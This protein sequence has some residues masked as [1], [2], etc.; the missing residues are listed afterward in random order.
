MV[1]SAS[2]LSAARDEVAGMLEELALSG[3][4]YEVEPDD[5]G[6]WSLVVECSASGGWKRV[7][8]VLPR[9]ALGSRDSGAH[10]QAVLRL[11]DALTD[12]LRTA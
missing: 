11:S 4:R 2:E 12:C 3:Y 7:E 8:L 1:I 10:R 5:E 6:R 9:V